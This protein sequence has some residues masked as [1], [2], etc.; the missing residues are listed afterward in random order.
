MTSRPRTA[1]ATAATREPSAASPRSP[2]SSASSERPESRHRGVRRQEQVRERDRDCLHE[3]QQRADRDR[4]GRPDRRARNG[5]EHERVQQALVALGVEHA[6]NC[7]QG[8]EQE[9]DP[10]GP[11][12][13]CDRGA[14]DIRAVVQHHLRNRGEQPHREREL[15]RT[16]L[17]HDIGAHE[18]AHGAG[19]RHDLRAQRSTSSC[20][21]SSHNRSARARSW[22]A[23]TTVTCPR[24]SASS[25]SSRA[26]LSSSSP[27]CGSSRTSRLGAGRRARAS[28]RRCRW[29][30]E[31]WAA[32]RSAASRRS[33]VASARSARSAP[34][35]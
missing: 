4:L 6:R 2:A 23:S 19:E 20:R 13:D 1:D 17:E 21:S 25:P 7:E 10:E 16:A 12:G 9:R 8:R 22:V 27:L 35:P 34:R 18:Q 32:G 3:Q 29:P 14:R 5:R 15:R 31:S 11:H 28:A 33:A 26:L 30:W 24:A